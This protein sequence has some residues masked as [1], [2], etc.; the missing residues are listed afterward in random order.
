MSASTRAT[1]A[2][3]APDQGGHELLGQWAGT[4][5][6]RDRDQRVQVSLCLLDRT[7]DRAEHVVGPLGFGGGKLLSRPCLDHDHG[8]A[9][10]NHIMQLAGDPRSFEPNGFGR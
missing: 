4:V 10:G 7:E 6:V 3:R 5:K 9:V 8:E 1:S 2:D